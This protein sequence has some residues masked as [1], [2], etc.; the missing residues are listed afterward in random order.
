METLACMEFDLWILE[1]GQPSAKILVVQMYVV[2][3]MIS[4]APTPRVIYSV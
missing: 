3:C 4:F 2:G 1:K